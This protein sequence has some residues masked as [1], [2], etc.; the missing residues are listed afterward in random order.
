MY[1]S[2]TLYFICYRI[3]STHN[4]EVVNAIVEA[5]GTDVY[6]YEVIRSKNFTLPLERKRKFD[7]R[8]QKHMN[9]KTKYMFYCTY[10]HGQV[11]CMS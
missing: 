8:I 1:Y 5:I 2:M 9:Q 7:L 6:Q 3:N 10:V 4:T 11:R